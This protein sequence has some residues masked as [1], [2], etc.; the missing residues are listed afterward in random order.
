MVMANF[1]S[2][3]KTFIVHTLPV[4]NEVL[5]RVREVVFPKTLT[6]DKILLQL[7]RMPLVGYCCYAGVIF[8]YQPYARADR[9]S[10]CTHCC[11]HKRLL[12]WC[13]R[14]AGP[15]IGTCVFHAG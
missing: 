8:G 10:V 9:L 14:A 15:T 4:N 3:V 11:L 6:I 7:E 13:T 12:A 1:P 2:R 5:S